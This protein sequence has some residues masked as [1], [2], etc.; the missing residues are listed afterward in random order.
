MMYSHDSY[1]LGHLRRTLALAE[2]FV[3][4]N[5]KTNVLLLT[6][7]T[8]SNSYR[9]SQGIDI[10]KLPSAVKVGGGKYESSRLSISFKRLKQ[11]RSTLIIGAAESFEP[12]VFLVDKAPLGMKSEVEDTLRFLNDERP[13]TLNVLG[14]RDVMDDPGQVR[15]SWRER[16]IPE[17]IEKLY[18]LVLVYGPREVYDP[19]SE[20]GLHEGTIA[21]T[22]YVGY[23][24][25]KHRLKAVSELPFEPGYALVT[26]GGGGDGLK[27]IETYLKGLA[28]R[29]PDHDSII[30][31]GP[32]MSDRD[33]RRVEGL[34][35]G[36][37]VRVLEFRADMEDL[38]QGA[39]V[40]VAMGGYNTTTELLEAR[41]PALIVP[42][43][44]PRVEQLIRA[45][46]LT[47]LGLT[48][49]IHPDELTPELMRAKVEDLFESRR[50]P[51]VR[52]RVDLS[53]ADR[54]VEVVTEGLQNLRR[55]RRDA[56]AVGA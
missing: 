8:V 56:E 45:E 30:V 37:R 11:L 38:I 54:A 10:L 41:K 21:R 55:G 36:L 33:R 42:R 51:R 44:E 48:Q 40:V 4:A 53:G 32:M 1:G 52:L 9:M 46:R 43:V 2:A 3:E 23:I 16:G 27:V 14:L 24:G 22:H 49:M 17:S 25:K 34:A 6:G 7:S 28:L 39:G 29:E 12:D 5:P 47:G 35:R 18:D 20:Y 26:P 13:A 50:A 31:T 15:H 19:L